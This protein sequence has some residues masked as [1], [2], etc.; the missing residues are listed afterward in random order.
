MAVGI[1]E[2]TTRS[3]TL[4]YAADRFAESLGIREAQDAATQELLS[5]AERDSLS[6]VHLGFETDSGAPR[7]MSVSARLSAVLFDL[8]SANVLV[9]AGLQLEAPNNQESFLNDARQQVAT[10][11]DELLAPTAVTSGFAPS[12]K[13]QSATLQSATEQFRNYSGQLLGEIAG[14]VE[15]TVKIGMT[16]LGKLDPSE[17]TKALE[18]IG[19]AAPIIAGAGQLVR[20]GLEKLKRA[21]EALMEMFGTGTIKKIK[22]QIEKIVKEAGVS[23]RALLDSLLGVN[24]VNE[25]IKAILESSALNISKLDSATNSLPEIARDFN[26]NNKMLRAVMRAIQLA[27]LL[28]PVLPFAAPWH[29][30][31]LAIAYV[32]S[33]GVTV[34]VGRQYTGAWRVLTWIDGVEQIADGIP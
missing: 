22:E 9:G 13:L 30:P 10:T 23:G 5:V 12:L 15:K 8:Q 17:I 26:G 2:Y 34:L 7:P 18:Q 1:A 29:V 21:I 6:G 27:G 25:R 31:T 4:L 14:E 19:E 3:A 28:L 16:E 24:F 20:K 32:S 11:R 33:I